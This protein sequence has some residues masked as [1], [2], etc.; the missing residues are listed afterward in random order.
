MLLEISNVSTLSTQMFNSTNCN[1]IEG[2]SINK[3]V[4]ELTHSS[5]KDN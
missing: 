3:I 4:S 5:P 1:V 2:Y